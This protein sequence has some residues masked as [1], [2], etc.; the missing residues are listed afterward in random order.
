MFLLMFVLGVWMR[1]MIYT[2]KVRGIGNDQL[3][4]IPVESLQAMCLLRLC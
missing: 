2:K 1:A 4:S 3:E